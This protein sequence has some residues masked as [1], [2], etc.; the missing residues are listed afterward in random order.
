MAQSKDVTVTFVNPH[1]SRGDWC[2]TF[3]GKAFHPMD[4]RP[5]E[6]EILD[7]AHALSM[8][9]RFCGHCREFY[10]VAE[11]SIRCSVNVP[12]AYALAALM[13]DASE[14]YIADVLRPIKPYLIGYKDI[15]SNVMAVIAK[16][17]GFQ[18]PLPAIVKHIDN[19]MLY[20][21]K[22]DLLGTSPKEWC[23][24][25]TE[26]LAEVIIP[27]KDNVREIF[28]ARFHYLTQKK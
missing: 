6:I 21:E 7:I 8:V 9:C 3:T 16:K 1:N 10:S 26:P 20:T 11:H 17:Y 19:V 15:E 18:W 23:D 22:R 4:P 2:Q 13:H 27:M 5:E 12:E 28:L 25:T 24:T 14:A